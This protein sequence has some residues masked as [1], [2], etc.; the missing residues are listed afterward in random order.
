MKRNIN[1]VL[2]FG[3]KIGFTLVRGAKV[4]AQRAGIVSERPLAFRGEFKAQVVGA[5][6]TVKAEHTFK[7]GVVNI[8]LDTILNVMFDALAQHTTWYLGLISSA[9][10]VS[11]DSDDT[12]GSHGNWLEAN[13]SNLPDY[14][15]SARPQ[16]DPA[17]S[18]ARSSVNTV[19]VDFTINQ[20]G[21]V[22][23]IF[24]TS[25]ATKAG[26]AGILWAHGL[27]PGGDQ[28]VV[29]GDVLKITYTVNAAAA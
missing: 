6:G 24:L 10:F 12:M 20:T 8:G 26:T 9:S 5:D 16:W 7:N 19:T 28:A 13:G 2:G 14:D 11:I 1:R 18:T 3:Q 17:A 23:G 25:D 15:E 21:T 27:F 29:S 4:I 22:K